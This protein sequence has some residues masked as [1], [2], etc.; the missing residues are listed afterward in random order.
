MKSGTSVP[1]LVGLPRR[2]SGMAPPSRMRRARRLREDSV[3]ARSG[4]ALGMPRMASTK[5]GAGAGSC[6]ARGVKRTRPEVLSQSRTML[7]VRMGSPLWCQWARR[8]AASW[9]AVGVLRLLKVLPS[10]WGDSMKRKCA[11]QQS[12][13]WAK[14]MTFK[15]IGR[16]VRLDALK[17]FL[18]VLIRIPQ[19]D[20]SAVGTCGGMLGFC[21]FDEEP[22][23]FGR[24]EGLV[25][26]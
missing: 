22:V 5:L 8:A 23:D 6:A 16:G 15:E 2:L 3:A 11:L 17:C 7:I 4:V 18:Y 26:L 25:D 13:A 20:G 21:E 24:V 10:C 19:S 14:R 1:V 9:S 12:F